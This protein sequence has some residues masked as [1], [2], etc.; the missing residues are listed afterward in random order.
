[1]TPDEFR[2]Y[3]RDLQKSP[4]GWPNDYFAWEKPDG[5]LFMLGIASTQQYQVIKH[6]MNKESF[7]NKNRIAWGQEPEYSSVLYGISPNVSYMQAHL[8]GPTVRYDPVEKLVEQTSQYRYLGTWRDPDRLM[9]SYYGYNKVLACG[10]WELA[11]QHIL[12]PE[13][14]SSLSD[15]ISHAADKSKLQSSH[16]PS[17]DFSLSD[18][19]QR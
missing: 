6:E 12:Q 8:N 9:E 15:Q 14:K 16:S 19:K 2:T 7:Q 3:L 11:K 17:K 4:Y 5:T 18:P 10:R 1:M 13:R